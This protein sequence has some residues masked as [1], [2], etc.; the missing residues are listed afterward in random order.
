MWAYVFFFLQVG[1]NLYAHNEK[2]IIILKIYIDFSLKSLVIN[3]PCGIF[4]LFLKIALTQN[5]KAYVLL[6]N[7]KS[8][9]EQ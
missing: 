6:Q 1:I 3:N 7:V 4:I 2:M 5:R 9:S 8:L